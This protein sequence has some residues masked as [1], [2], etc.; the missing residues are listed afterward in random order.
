MREEVD[1][2]EMYDDLI[3]GEEEDNYGINNNNDRVSSQDAQSIQEAPAGY[4]YTI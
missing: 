4:R 1:T 3:L 2:D